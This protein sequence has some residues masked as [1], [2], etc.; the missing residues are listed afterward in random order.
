M[1]KI[2]GFENCLQQENFIVD[3]DLPEVMVTFNFLLFLFKPWL[4]FLGEF[5][6]WSRW[7]SSETAHARL[8]SIIY[9]V[10]DCYILYSLSVFNAKREISYIQV[11]MLCSIYCIN[12][13]EISNHFNWFF[14]CKWCDLLCNNSIMLIFSCVEMTCHFNMWG[15]HV[16]VQKLTRY[17]IGEYMMI[18]Q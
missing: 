2:W 15:Y 7:E 6:W 11:A 18:L 16:F 8:D 10:S 17:F 9:D 3:W 1:K 4:N 14:C 12:T 13:N 5:R